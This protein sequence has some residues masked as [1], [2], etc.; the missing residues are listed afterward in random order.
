MDFLFKMFPFFES[1]D[2]QI[3][4]INQ[5]TSDKL[6]ESHFHN[7][8]VINSSTIGSS[9]SRNLALQNTIGKLVVIS[10]DDVVFENDFTQKILESYTKKNSADAICFR[11]TKDDGTLLKK[12]PSKEK[13]NINSLDILNVGNIEI[14]LN[15]QKI[16][17]SEIYFDENFGLNALF[18]LGEEA[19]FLSDLK[20]NGYRIDFIPKTI[21]MHASI[22]TSSKLIFSERY[23][24]YGALFTRLF[25]S[26]YWLWIFLKLFF[27]CKQG[28][29]LFK[30]IPK[31]L[32][33]AIKGREKFISLLNNERKN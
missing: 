10:D 30:N 25:K 12:Y 15:Y 32:K 24:I 7:V 5:T 9:K 29:I 13:T 14:T 31:S 22:T 2:F 21:V 26:N 16:K 17:N 8:R 27:D 18:G 33:M 3:L 11:A 6:L 20:S 4:I 19:V 28:Q 1:I 23:F